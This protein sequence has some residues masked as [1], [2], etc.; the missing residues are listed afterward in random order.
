MLKRIAKLF[1]WFIIFFCISWSSNLKGI[2][3]GFLELYPA[4]IIIF[5]WLI[6]IFFSRKSYA[7]KQVVPYMKGFLFLGTILMFLNMQNALTSIIVYITMFGSMLFS[8]FFTKN[9][10][11]LKI[12]S[13]GILL[14][15]LLMEGIAIY[16]SF[17][18]NFILMNGAEKYLVRSYNMFGTLSPKAAFFNTNNLTVYCALCFPF[19]MFCLKNKW[20]KLIGLFVY[21]ITVFTS[22]LTNSRTGI[23]CFLI[24]AFYYLYVNVKYSKGTKKVLY[25]F[26]AFAVSFYVSSYIPSI[27]EVIFPKDSG[28]VSEESRLTIWANYLEICANHIFLGGWPGS[29]G[30]L[31]M[32]YYGTDIPPHNLFLEILV[33]LGIIGFIVFLKIIKPIIPKYSQLKNNI[34]YQ[35]TILFLIIF[36]MSTICP[37][38]MMGYYF[39]W[40]L[41]GISLSINKN[42]INAYE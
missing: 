5:T 21:V 33:D 31:N 30:V 7:G 37:S 14:N 11:D 8:S 35:I 3:I 17:T 15:L 34:T 24:C 23:L 9:S 41:F 27:A 39:M 13:L 20:G 6:Y 40:F 12:I 25:F 22:L 4:R 19:T 32:Q 18:G 29:S 26:V 28:G 16:E 2:N 42:K 38:S 10:A 1:I 36:M